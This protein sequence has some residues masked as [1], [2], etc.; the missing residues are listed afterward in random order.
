MVPL[1][2]VQDQHQVCPYLEK[3]TA[4][5][6]LQ[7]P[8][9]EVLPETTDQILEM[10]Y[11]RSGEFL[12]RTQ[13][14][15]CDQ[16]KP[17][18]VDIN[19][20]RCTR[21]L[22]RVIQRGRRDLRIELGQ[23]QFNQRRVDL[24]NQHRRDRDLAQSDAPVDVEAYR[25]FLVNSCC[26]SAELAIYRGDNLIAVSIFDVGQTSTSAV[27]T[28]FDPAEGRYSLGTLAVL[29]QIQWGRQTGRQWTYL[30]MYVAANSH[31]NYKARFAP[32]QRLEKGQWIDYD[33]A[34]LGPA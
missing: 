17:T 24:F 16:C 12:Y 9:G 21:S 28:Y 18:R 32:Q 14:P 4:R 13:C 5:M 15:T 8:A 33:D 1:I 20:F 23:P 22:R 2:V 7:L 29:E 6:P 19:R 10:G 25:S 27:Y 3:T 34:P 11:R 30:G 31:L 26:L